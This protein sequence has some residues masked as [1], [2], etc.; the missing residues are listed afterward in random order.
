MNKNYWI[1]L[2]FSPLFA[3]LLTCIT[4]YYQLAVIGSQQ[5]TTFFKVFHG[6]GFASINY[7][8]YKKKL[9]NNPKIFHRY[10]QFHGSLKKIRQ[11]EFII[12]KNDSMIDV[13]DTLLSNKRRT[14]KI[15]I[16]EGKNIFEIADILEK[17]YIAKKKEF[18]RYS[19]DPEL[20]KKLNIPSD[21]ME[22]YLFPETYFFTKGSH[23]RDIIEE[24]VATFHKKF[25]SLDRSRSPLTDP[26]VVIL[27]SI[28]EKETGVAFERS[29]IS[30]VFH[31]RLLKKM[32]LQSDPTT[33][34]GIFQTFTGNLKK[35]HLLQKTPYNTYKI[36]G[37]P[38]GAISNP[39]LLSLKAAITPQKHDYFYFVSKNNGTHVFS[40]T[41]KEHKKAVVLWQKK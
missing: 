16:P 32:R 15:T 28:I 19:K 17:K 14:F 9:I 36:K 7:R 18:L 8:L 41:Y 29:Q 13:L 25:L 39:G 5:E 4:L 6:E 11:G 23:P 34:Y 1:F 26:E 22:G 12:K 31:N 24:M 37:L 3:I 21:S 35:S 20:L 10:T 2:F 27:A 38:K 30:G 33:I 40:K